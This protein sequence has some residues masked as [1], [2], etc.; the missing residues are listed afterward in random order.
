MQEQHLRKRRRFLG[1]LMALGL[2]TSLQIAR[3]QTAPAADETELVLSVPG[4]GNTVSLPLELA[5]RLGFDR[6]EG[7][8][9]RLRFVGGGGVSLQD[10]SNGNAAYGVFGVPAAMNHNLKGMPLVVALA[11]IDRLPLYALMVRNDLRNSVRSVADLRGRAIGIH[12]NALATR[13]T[14]HQLLDL[15]LRAQGVP[16]DSVRYLAAGQS[17]ETQSAAFISRAVDASMCDEPIA[18]RLASEGLAFQLYSTGD[19]KDARKTPGAGF[20]RA[21][22]MTRADRVAQRPDEAERVVRVVLRT[23]RWLSQADGER[24]AQTLSLSGEERASWMQLF[25]RYPQ[26]YSADGKFSA[27]Q[28]RDTDV[29]FRASSGNDAAAAGYAV[30]SMVI[31]RFVGRKA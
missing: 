22:L 12:S 9:L 13:T 30:E 29:F 23:L 5:V 4:P 31:D 15:V 18:T 25:R 26:M 16:L 27:A 10:L 6:A 2:P 7:I 17:Y 1:A 24:V 21:A 8:A 20:L 14:S 3:A 28:L 19:A 11:A